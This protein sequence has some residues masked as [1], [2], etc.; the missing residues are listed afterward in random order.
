MGINLI[1]FNPPSN[2][3]NN[4]ISI[5]SVTPSQREITNG[6]QFGVCD[7]FN[8]VFPMITCGKPPGERLQLLFESLS[9][10][11]AL[12]YDSHSQ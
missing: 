4:L 11:N 7:I 10:S 3:I 5:A 2:V 6:E 12:L 8:S 9:I 1:S